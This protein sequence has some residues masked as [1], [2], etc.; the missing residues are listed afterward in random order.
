MNQALNDETVTMP[1]EVTIATL[2]AFSDA[3]NR[4]DLPCLMSFMHPDCIFET[5]GGPEAFGSRHVGTAEVAKAFEL[6]WLHCPDARWLDDQHFVQGAQGMSQ[7][8]FCGTELDGTRIE[9]WGVDVLTFRDGKIAVKNA[10][11]KN[12]P[13]LPKQP[14]TDDVILQQRAKL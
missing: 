9:V 4:H 7:W 10:F 13:R 8:T 12:R 5:A 1:C 3:W 11:R 2:K 6:A 14:V